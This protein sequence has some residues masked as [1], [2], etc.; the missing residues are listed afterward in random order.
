MEGE[1]S[2]ELYV[3]GEMIY[4]DLCRLCMEVEGQKYKRVDIADRKGL[5]E[6]RN[7]LSTELS[8]EQNKGLLYL[9]CLVDRKNKRV[10]NGSEA[11][12]TYCMMVL[13]TSK[14]LGSS[15][16]DLVRLVEFNQILDGVM[17]KLRDFSN[18]SCDVSSLME[19]C[20]KPRLA[21]LESLAGSSFLC[22]ST[23]QMVDLYMY[24]ICKIISAIDGS[25]IKSYPNLVRVIDTIA[26][27]PTVADYEKSDRRCKDNSPTVSLMGMDLGL[28]SEK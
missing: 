23:I 5:E 8:S 17:L 12:S 26:K 25:V 1:S 19:K 2:L 18:K 10:V 11:I 28:D 24:R 6:L 9:P 16:V 4:D 22:G 21:I 7:S 3:S 14:L 15:N 13:S 27:M 20:V